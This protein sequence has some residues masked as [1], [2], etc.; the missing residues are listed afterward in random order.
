MGNFAAGDIGR[1]GYDHVE[2]A[3]EALSPIALTN[4]RAPAQTMGLGIHLGGQNGARRGIDSDSS[5]VPVFGQ[6]R[7]EERAGSGT[8]VEDSDRSSAIRNRG[9]DRLDQTFSV[10]ARIESRWGDIE[11]KR[12]EVTP[13]DDTCDRLA[14]RPTRQ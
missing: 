9:D 1:V 14:R 5:S 8:E 10:G 13:S 6:Q 4:R 2:R 3:R 12:P 7:Q 11:V